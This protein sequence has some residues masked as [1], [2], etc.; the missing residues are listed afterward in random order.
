MRASRKPLVYLF[1]L[2]SLIL[3]AR[4][5]RA[6]SGKSPPVPQQA[7]QQPA[8]G[9]VLTPTPAHAAVAAPGAVRPDSSGDLVFGEPI[10]YHNL[11]LVP[12]GTLRRGPF[13]RYTL[14]EQ[15]LKDRSLE[16]RELS[17]NV[18]QAQV[19]AVEVR[20]RGND[21]VYL[22][23]GEM[24][25][26][27]KQDRIIQQDTVLGT[28]GAWQ[29]VAVFCVERGRWA[30]Q[31][32][33]FQSGGAVAHVALRTAALTGSQGAVWAEVARSN[34]QHG[35][36]SQTDTYRRTIQ[37][38]A[39]R[40]K[41]DPYRQQLLQLFPRDLQLAGLVVGINGQIRVADLFGNPVL[42][43]QLRDKLL[44]SYILEALGARED[45]VAP[46]LS[47]GA[48]QDWLQEARQAK[49]GKA[50]SAGRA[51]S[52]RKES[53][54]SVGMETIDAASAAPVREVYIKK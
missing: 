20:N 39:L 17:G 33:Q 16:V 21:P 23:G 18:E 2:L 26:G 38:E 37:N 7:A 52:Y 9:S 46:V 25:L 43:G 48:A 27:G 14:L 47:K 15:G 4:G 51:Q 8:A 1:M 34:L 11:T 36:Q 24:I 45:R 35:T 49:K 13:Q 41:I 30:G 50:E 5:A 6:G 19:S 28:G 54:S 12:V 3:C 31:N 29:K 22:L 53:A 32:M 42:F 10:R 40:G 44:S